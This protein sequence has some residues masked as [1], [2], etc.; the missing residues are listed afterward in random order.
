MDT[1]LVPRFYLEGFTDPD[2]PSGHCPFVWL[3]GFATGSW[4]RKSPRNVATSPDYY[5][6]A[7]GSENKDESCEQFLS[8]IE[9]VA[10]PVIRSLNTLCEPLSEKDRRAIA[11]FAALMEAR[12]PARIRHVQGFVGEV[13]KATFSRLWHHFRNDPGS[14]ERFRS[15]YRE[16]TGRDDLAGFLS[17]SMDPARFHIEATKEFVLPI[18]LASVRHLAIGLMVLKW[19]LLVCQDQDVFIT[20]DNPCHRFDPPETPPLLRGGLANEGVEFT[21][22]LT[23]RVALL[24]SWTGV[25]NRRRLATTAEVRLLNLRTASGAGQYIAAPSVDFPGADEIRAAVSARAAT[26]ESTS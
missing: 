24:A 25:D 21:L 8:R 4:K 7:N 6:L 20:S 5:L 14:F 16:Q 18:I 19:C 23:S 11:W 10:A 9:S 1:H 17:D 2:V 22:P 26:Q 13:T 15:R 3:L 12:L